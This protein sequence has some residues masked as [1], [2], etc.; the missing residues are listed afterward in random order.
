[1]DKAQNKAH[2]IQGGSSAELDTPKSVRVEEPTD[3][4]REG[5]RSAVNGKAPSE[6]VVEGLRGSELTVIGEVERR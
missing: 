5:Y 6:L 3:N 4:E 1:M 2:L